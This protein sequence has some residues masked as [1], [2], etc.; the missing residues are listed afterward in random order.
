MSQ[1]PVDPL[2]PQPQ[3]QPEPPRRRLVDTLIATGLGGLAGYGAAR[4]LGRVIEGGYLR[5][6]HPDALRNVQNYMSHGNQFRGAKE[7]HNNPAEFQ[8]SLNRFPS[9]RGTI[10]RGVRPDHPTEITRLNALK[11]GDVYEPGKAMSADKYGP[12][13]EQSAAGRFK[14]N[15][16]FGAPAPKRGPFIYIKTDNA[17]DVGGMGRSGFGWDEVVTL[18]DSKFKVTRVVR[19]EAGEVVEVYLE[20]LSRRS[21]AR[22]A[23]D[24]GRD[25]VSAGGA[26]AGA[27][28]GGRV[29]ELREE[30][31]AR[32]AGRRK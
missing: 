29:M 32:R 3:P 8:R 28:T 7:M 20:D 12:I 17:R 1:Q 25:A 11:E 30:E 27:Y 21:L 5:Y 16:T 31:Q 23:V 19:N 2:Q 18:P 13:S 6:R 10:R 26:G 4:G 9:Y 24:V 22:R 15:D 14:E